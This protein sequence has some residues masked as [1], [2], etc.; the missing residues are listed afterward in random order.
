MVV[1]PPVTAN[2]AATNMNSDSAVRR[3][4]SCSIADPV[5]FKRAPARAMLG[6]LVLALTLVVDASAAP[7][8]ED[9]FAVVDEDTA[10][11]TIDVADNDGADA[12]PSTVTISTQ[13][14]NGTAV[15]NGD[16]IEL[17]YNGINI[18]ADSMAVTCGPLVVA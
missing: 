3:T 5:I 9:D 1:K 10:G 4:S 17:Y 16:S 12:I 11:N 8:P 6:L 15:S 14:L 7:T 2:M 13:P 18:S